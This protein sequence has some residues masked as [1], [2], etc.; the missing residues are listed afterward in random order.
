[1]DPDIEGMRNM[2]Q[3]SSNVLLESMGA[4]ILLCSPACEYVTHTGDYRVEEFNDAL[5]NILKIEKEHLE[6]RY[7]S[8]V[9][10][11]KEPSFLSEFQHNVDSRKSHRFEFFSKRVGAY[12]EVFI[13]ILK[14]NT[15]VNAFIDITEKKVSQESLRKRVEGLTRPLGDTSNVKFEDLFDINEI[16]TIQDAFAEA[17]GVASIITAP[18]GKPIT[19]QSRFCRLC[20]SVIRATEK[21]MK[22]CMHS[23]AMLGRVNPDGPLMQPCLSGGLWDGGTSIC[24]G[25]HHIANWLIGQVLDES[26]DVEPMLKYARE[27]GADEEDFRKALSEVNQMPKKHFRDICQALFLIARQLSQL[28]L[29]NL[30]Q[31]RHI[32]ERQK[33]EEALVQQLNLVRSVIDTS[34]N[35]IL[36]CDLN[37]TAIECNYEELALLGYSSKSELIGRNIY[38][39][40]AFDD[41]EVMRRSERLLLELGSIKNVEFKIKDCLGREKLI[42]ASASIVRDSYD[43]PFYYIIISRDISDRRKAEDELK[44][45]KMT[46]EVANKV[47]SEFL[48]NMSHE[49]RTPMN[50]IIGMIDLMLSNAEREGQK[51]S[52]K[53]VKLS[54]HN[55]LG[56]INNI[57]DLS[58]VESG[59]LELEKKP[60]LLCDTISATMKI[61][62]NQAGQKQIPLTWKISSSVPQRVVGDSVRLNQIIINLIGNA[63]KFTDTGSISFSV[64]TE[65]EYEG[66]ALLSFTVKDTGSGI[67]DDKL[68]VIF[69]ASARPV[70]S[71]TKRYEGSGLGL[72][73]SRKLV[74]LMEGSIEAESALGVGSTF[75][76]V[77]PFDISHEPADA[78]EKKVAE[79]Q[80]AAQSK[81]SILVVEDEAINRRVIVEYLTRL[82]HTVVQA[83]NGR[84]AVEA[85]EH[86]PF[87]MIFMDI[88]MPEMNGVD[89]TRAIRMRDGGI[90]KVYI[91]AL[92]AYAMKEDRERFIEAGVDDYI[93]KPIELEELSLAIERYEEAELKRQS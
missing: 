39:I 75:R 79:K 73:I 47:K 10:Q 31:A 69:D 24:A 54:A 40:I 20:N 22:N 29:R 58:K 44:Q 3:D 65:S 88:Q 42:E 51:D 64:R 30:Q 2:Q 86:H 50:G 66:K 82:G 4:G 12:L 83:Q 9:F 28:A 77:V 61:Y 1:M 84:M 78:E 7:V 41:A 74:E 27:I 8:E 87:D 5:M 80:A 56:I 25:D 59:K 11:E 71:M 81:H 13:M 36:I 85:Y 70:S 19:R 26:V 60:F 63:I 93:T 72:I 37:G 89:A 91:T 18:D 43:V 15:V 35:A 17:T 48:A 90:R 67:P 45:A 55:L 6:G 52:L 92:T 33:A 16:Q 46:A 38:Q 32:T 76:F 14:D 62:A 49:I 68:K 57:L 34:P 53:L 23:D 21:G